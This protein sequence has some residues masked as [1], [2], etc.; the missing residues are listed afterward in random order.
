MLCADKY[1]SKCNAYNPL[2]LAFTRHLV[3]GILSNHVYIDINVVAG[4]LTNIVADAVINIVSDTLPNIVAGALRG[5]RAT[6]V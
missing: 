5:R 1:L 6:G 2:F 3:L 4:A